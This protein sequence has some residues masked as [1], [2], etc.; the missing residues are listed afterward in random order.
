[1][2]LAERLFGLTI[3]HLALGMIAAFFARLELGTRIGLKYLPIVPCHALTLCQASLLALWSVSSRDPVKSRMIGVLLGAVYLEVTVPFSL[4]SEFLGISSLAVAL[5]IVSLL[6]MRAMGSRV[7]RRVQSEAAE[8][9]PPED[10]KLSIGGIMVFTAVVALMCTLAKALQASGPNRLLLTVV[11]AM[12]FVA[13][14]LMCLWAV[15][16]K[17]RLIHRA[18]LVFLISPL[19]GAF[20]AFAVEAHKTGWAYIL[21][22]MT[23][24]PAV[25]IGSLCVVRSCGYRFVGKSTDSRASIATLPLNSD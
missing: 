4:S 13:V 12:C 1:M 5:T 20:F 19:L 18:P 25:L 10:L 8:Q 17:G 7:E 2:P 11:W 15:L 23:L 6:V 14:G 9:D 3:L 22:I 24:Y 21:L 16:G